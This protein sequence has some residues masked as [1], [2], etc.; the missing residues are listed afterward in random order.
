MARFF[1][2][3]EYTNGNY[4]LTDIIEIALFSDISGFTFHTYV[5]I[6]NCLP[7]FVRKLTGITDKMLQDIGLPFPIA[8]RRMI[9]FIRGELMDNGQG[10]SPVIVAHGGVQQDF[11]ILLANCVRYNIDY[12]FLHQCQFIDSV[13]KL[14]ENG[15][16]RPGLDTFRRP[17]DKKHFFFFI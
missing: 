13:V 4:Y 5:K 6:D 16:E 2:D 7:Q 14:S 15:Y 3:L 9:E 11:P 8:F 1:L 12:L 17:G 10:D